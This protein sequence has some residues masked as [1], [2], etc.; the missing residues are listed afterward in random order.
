MMP[1]KTILLHHL[2]I[3]ILEITTIS[4]L[5]RRRSKLVQIRAT[6]RL[7]LKFMKR[8]RLRQPKSLRQPD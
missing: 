7:E 5:R 3:M 1:L 6:T 4:V 8:V 2:R